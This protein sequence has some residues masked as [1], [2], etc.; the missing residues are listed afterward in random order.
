MSSPPK[1]NVVYTKLQLRILRLTLKHDAAVCKVDVVQDE[2]SRV[3]FEILNVKD[4]FVFCSRTC[5]CWSLS[6]SFNSQRY[7]GWFIS[8]ETDVYDSGNVVTQDLNDGDV[9]V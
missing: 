4:C 6:N 5:Q 8:M 3:V 7:F 9:L 1:N 2:E